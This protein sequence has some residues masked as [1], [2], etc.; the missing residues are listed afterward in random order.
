MCVS[1]AEV[2]LARSKASELSREQ[3]ALFTSLSFLLAA[4]TLLLLL[5]IGSAD[6]RGENDLMQRKLR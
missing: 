2:L 4:A 3:Q 1:L 5:I 6:A